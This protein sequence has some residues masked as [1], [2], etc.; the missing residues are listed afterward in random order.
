MHLDFD[1][2]PQ[3]YVQNE[4]YVPISCVHK[5]KTKFI[6]F[7]HKTTRY[8]Q[9]TSTFNLHTSH[10]VGLSQI[11]SS[12]VNTSSWF[13]PRRWLGLL[14]QRAGSVTLMIFTMAEH[15]TCPVQIASLHA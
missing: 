8:T 11:Y 14:G 9:T 5:N 4:C 2:M 13:G 1:D 3:T 10:W 6:Y 7:V 12:H 15:H